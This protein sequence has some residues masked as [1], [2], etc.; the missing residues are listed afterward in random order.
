MSPSPFEL[1]TRVAVAC[2]N[3]RDRK[4][5]CIHESDQASCMR[6][7]LNGLSCQYVATKK[8][9]ERRLNAATKVKRT[10]TRKPAPLP[11]PSII[12]PTPPPSDMD[13]PMSMHDH[14][15]LPQLAHGSSVGSPSTASSLDGLSPLSAEFLEFHSAAS[16]DASISPVQFDFPIP[17]SPLSSVSS[18]PSM[19]SMPGPS[20]L[21]VRPC[22]GAEWLSDDASVPISSCI[23][24]KRLG[25]ASRGAYTHTPPTPA[26]QVQ[27]EL[28]D[29]YHSFGVVPPTNVNVG[30]EVPS[31]YPMHPMAYTGDEYNAHNGGWYDPMSH[32][33]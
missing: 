29:M 7:Q 13:S 32:S 21:R 10:R 24:N 30:F 22:I 5:K 4:V 25:F 2:S 26:V 16:S 31:V 23:S 6:C 8:Q 11:V 33:W 9:R 12:A 27:A 19:P 1:P 3:C 15:D 14:D 18:I 28:D 20:A 17:P